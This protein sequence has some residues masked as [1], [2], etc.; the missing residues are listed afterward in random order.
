VIAAA[1]RFPWRREPFA[2]FATDA[3]LLKRA[4]SE[5]EFVHRLVRDYVALRELL[6]AVTGSER[7]RRLD[8]IRSLGYQGESAIEVL[9]ELA[10]NEDASVRAAAITGLSHITSPVRQVLKK[11]MPD[12]AEEVRQAL[13]EAMVRVAGRDET[14]FGL[15]G[16]EEYLLLDD[17]EPIGDGSEVETVLRCVT[18][19]RAQDQ[20][21]EIVIRLGSSA[22][23]P[24]LAHVADRDEDIRIAAIKALG[25]LGDHQAVRPLRARLAREKNSQMRL[26]IIEAL[27][28]LGEF[29]DDWPARR[30][31]YGHH[32]CPPGVG[33]EA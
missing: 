4:G 29:E 17:M 21:V 30:S 32:G 14:T 11:C 27:V 22:V 18:G 3:F 5:Y 28:C 9:V 12:T 16:S 25:L 23:G 15:V 13:I 8:A 26:I 2:L 33:A 19:L 20:A 31:G 6:P 24:L 1:A 10:A 7:R